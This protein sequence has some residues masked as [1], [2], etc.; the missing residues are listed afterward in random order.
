M[1]YR[2]DL[3]TAHTE[4][5]IDRVDLAPRQPDPAW[6]RKVPPGPDGRQRHLSVVCDMVLESRRVQGTARISLPCPIVVMGGSNLLE[7]QEL[8]VLFANRLASG[9]GVSR[10][11]E[12]GILTTAGVFGPNVVTRWDKQR[13]E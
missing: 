1:P 3:V 13:P 5:P 10:I 8:V 7:G 12:E 6:T 9:L 11:G 2:E 4:P